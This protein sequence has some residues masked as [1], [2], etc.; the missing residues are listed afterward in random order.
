MR[1]LCCHIFDE[2][3]IHKIKL[4]YYKFNIKGEYCYKKIGFKEEG[5]LREEI[6]RNK[7]YQD[8]IV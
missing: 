6:F 1:T 7:P 2:M 4:Q 8:I 5:I 3:N